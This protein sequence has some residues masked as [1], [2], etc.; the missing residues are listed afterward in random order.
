MGSGHRVA[1]CSL[2][3]ESAAYCADSV[4]LLGLPAPM[5]N[6][7][8]TMAGFGEAL[9]G[10]KRASFAKQLRR[11]EP[12]RCWGDIVGP[13][14]AAHTSPAGWR[15]TTLMITVEHNAW[16]QELQ[17]MKRELMAKI[18]TTC[19]D[20]KLKDIRFQVGK[21]EGA[22]SPNTDADASFQLPSLDQSEKDFARD[23]VR[24]VADDET[25]E[26]IRRLIEK[27]LSLKKVKRDA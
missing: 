12:W 6:K 5:R 9:S 20:T 23:T 16:M 1:F 10:V 19:P 17:F 8:K 2:T 25:R 18:S 13:S 21:I 15:G 27:D 14:L 7:R 26:T 11:Y 4:H 3:T 24:P 22:V